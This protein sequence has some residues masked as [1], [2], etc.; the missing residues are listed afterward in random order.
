MLNHS[1][2]L[3]ISLSQALAQVP[4]PYVLSCVIHIA[5][6]NMYQVEDR[7]SNETELKFFHL[8]FPMS[9]KLCVVVAIEN[10]RILFSEGYCS[11]KTLQSSKELITVFYAV[12]RY[13]TFPS[14]DF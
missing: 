6:F 3:S 1:G 13:Y 11:H 14:S 7:R 10:Y 5:A 12:H 9:L 2:S 8:Y 4:I